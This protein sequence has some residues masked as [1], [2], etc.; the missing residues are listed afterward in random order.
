[1]S[2]ST[3][4]G[5]P[6]SMESRSAAP[7][8]NTRFLRHIIKETDTH[9]AA[10]LAK[11]A[12]ESRARLRH[13]EKGKKLLEKRNI[14]RH[15]PGRLT[16]VDF[17]GEETGNNAR[18]RSRQD[19]SDDERDRSRRRRRDREDAGHARSDRKRQ[20][21]GSRRR[22]RERYDDSE[23]DNAKRSS[24]HY[25]TSKGL[26][27]DHR[28]SSRRHHYDSHRKDS[29]GHRSH[30]RRSRSPAASRSR[31]RSRSPRRHHKSSRRHNSR[32]R[33]PR[34]RS[35][36]IHD[37]TKH[38]TQ[39]AHS[40]REPSPRNGSDSD[41]LEDI[42]GPLPPSPAQ[43]NVR[44]RGRGAHKANSMAM[45]AR[46]SSTYDPQS[47][48]H[49]NSDVE[50]EWGDALEALKDRERWKQQGA[51][52]LKAAGF[53]DDQVKKWE[54][55]DEKTEE[56]V[57]WSRRGEDREWDKGKVFDADGDVGLKAEWGRLT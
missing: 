55:G 32:S 20:G 30:R 29:S 24:R 39:K 25:D 51:E 6:T 3:S 9:N 10:L 37:D 41:P 11:E 22:E 48:V 36:K 5:V 44:S 43:L 4:P 15:D 53:T 13:M 28:H 23:G 47:D 17:S 52:R 21:D 57:K 8:P 34:S 50:D 35:S 12:E 31:S 45:D 38:R 7:K 16:P 54:R 19:D 49:L 26:E 33:S 1:M 56:D 27:R 14:R 2:R 46:F 42:V 40:R 18:K